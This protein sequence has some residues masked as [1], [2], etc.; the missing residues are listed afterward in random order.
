MS[1][2]KIYHKKQKE[3]TRYHSGTA[4]DPY[5]D[6]FCEAKNDYFSI[7]LTPMQ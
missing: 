5:I 1:Y 7:I 3:M 4:N 2:M 6:Y